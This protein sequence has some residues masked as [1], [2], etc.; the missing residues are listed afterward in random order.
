MKTNALLVGSV[1]SAIFLTACQTNSGYKTADFSSEKMYKKNAGATRPAP[2]P[3][4][5]LWATIT[6]AGTP[7]GMSG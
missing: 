5:T 4:G 2:R 7:T 3:A 6:S 1:A